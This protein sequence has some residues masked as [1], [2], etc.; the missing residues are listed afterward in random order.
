MLTMFHKL[1]PRI[2]LI[3]IMDKIMDWLLWSRNCHFKVIEVSIQVLIIVV[4]LWTWKIKIKQLIKLCWKVFEFRNKCVPVSKLCHKNYRVLVI[5]VNRARLILRILICTI[6]GWCHIHIQI[7]MEMLE[8][9]KINMETMQFSNITQP[10]DIHIVISIMVMEMPTIIMQNIRLLINIIDM[11]NNILKSMN[12]LVSMKGMGEDFKKGGFRERKVEVGGELIL[13]KNKIGQGILPS[14]PIR[15][16]V[17]PN[18]F[19]D[20]HQSQ[21][22]QIKSFQNLVLP[23]NN[24]AQKGI[25]LSV[26]QE[27]SKPVVLTTAKAVT[28]VD[29]VTTAVVK[30]SYPHQ[31]HK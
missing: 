18:R 12:K 29:L 6:M 23:K 25:I 16:K 21:N 14:F 30:R 15:L 4:M 7:Y 2:Q 20:T 28:Q 27:Q 5:V 26:F 24:Q 17:V 3:Q 19:Q 8:L 10:K 9:T 31:W 13:I 11:G 1:N 22:H